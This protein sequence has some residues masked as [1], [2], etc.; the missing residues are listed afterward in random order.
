[1]AILRCGR[2][3]RLTGKHASDFMRDTG[4]T[5]LPKTV[6]EYN[7]KLEKTAK[8][9]EDSDCPEGMVLAVLLYSDMLKE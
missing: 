2:Q 7:A 6:E 9:W 3:I 5:H 4:S 8:A 1:M